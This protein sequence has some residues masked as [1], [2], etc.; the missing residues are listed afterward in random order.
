MVGK[1]IQRNAPSF[2]FCTPLNAEPVERFDGDE[3]YF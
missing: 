3:I 1:T 2:C